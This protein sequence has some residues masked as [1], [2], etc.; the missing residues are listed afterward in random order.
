LW[1]WIR[2]GRKHALE[3][4]TSGLRADLLLTLG[5]LL[6][7]VALLARWPLAVSFGDEV[8]YLAEVR[9]MLDGRL[10]PLA[11]SPGVWVITDHGAVSKFPLL[12]PLILTPLFAIHPRLVFAA[13]A[14]AALGLMV[15]A[16][17]ILKAWGRSPLWALIVL[18]HPS[19]VIM[20]RTVMADLPLA[21]FGVA[22]WWAL[23]RGRRVATLVAFALVIA[24][25]AT[26]FA[27]AVVLLAGEAARCREEIRQRDRPTLRR[28]AWAAGGIGAGVALTAGLNLLSIGRLWFVY[29]EAHAYLAE[30]SFWPT[31]LRT[32]ARAHIASLLLLPPG[33]IIGAWPFWKRR[34]LGPLLVALGLPAMMCF[35]FFIDTGRQ[36]LE[37]LVMSPRLILP[38][39]A[40]L[41]VGYADCA[42][43]LARFVPPVARSLAVWAGVLGPAVLGFA[44][45]ARH[46]AWQEP[47]AMALAEASRIISA[48]GG[49]ERQELGLTHAATKAGVLF[50]GS[51][52]WVG[53]N[54]NH[55]DVVVCSTQSSSYRMPGQTASCD[56]PGYDDA[57]DSGTF[58]V[59]TR[60]A[61][62]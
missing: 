29:R 17:R 49:G 40:F 18:A 43:G 62:R 13:G 59:L 60:K 20:A 55:P 46:R 31:H 26:G 1:S 14:A 2:R 21:T 48:R 56:L 61:P 19:I 11:E 23:R 52:S 6:W 16:S 3:R 4:A 28:L 50:P 22:S 27:I 12:L 33:L 51:I 24:T 41:L 58:H 44:V 9:M 54:G 8:G 7:L 15:V 37:T 30:P 57:V 45:S 53:I 25:K 5:A 36:M 32:S 47:S 39:V 38:A 42:A 34:E 35:Y 10:R